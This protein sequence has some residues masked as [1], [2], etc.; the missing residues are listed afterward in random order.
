MWIGTL[1][2]SLVGIAAALIA[3][4]LPLD[5]WGTLILP[6]LAL[7]VGLIDG[8]GGSSLSGYRDMLRET[9]I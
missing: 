1:L 9:F 8:F 6:I 3:G 2:G 7:A 4:T 5:G